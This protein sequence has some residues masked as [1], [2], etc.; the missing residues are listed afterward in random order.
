MNIVIKHNNNYNQSLG[1]I[2]LKDPDTVLILCN[3][4]EIY[5][6][7]VPILT[8][9]YRWYDLDSATITICYPE[10]PSL[11]LVGNDSLLGVCHKF[12]EEHK[13]YPANLILITGNFLAP[14][15][16]QLWRKTNNKD[17]SSN[18]DLR[19]HYTHWDYWI[20]IYKKNYYTTHKKNRYFKYVNLN[21]QERWYR[22][23][24]LNYLYTNDFFDSGKNSCHYTSKNLHKNL[25]SKLPLVVDHLL[26]NSHCSD[27]NH[28]YDNTYFSIITETCFGISEGGITE[29]TYKTFY[30][31]HP[32][33]MVSS[34]GTLAILHELGFKT[35]NGLIDESYDDIKDDDKRMNAIQ[36]EIY[37]L[38]CMTLKELDEWHHSL[39]NIYDHNQNLLYQWSCTSRRDRPLLDHDKPENHKPRNNEIW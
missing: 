34:S 22:T 28:L 13:L 8:R 25:Q 7:I 16:Y 18:I 11:Q 1:A 21:G 39:N 10:E 27:Q 9:A 4:D 15:Y 23:E 2:D 35:F 6:R 37:K 36:K 12:M 38:C 32:F 33:V 19:V 31:R 5:K 20:H 3:Y 29:K 30:Y 24:I 14:E 17:D 26:P